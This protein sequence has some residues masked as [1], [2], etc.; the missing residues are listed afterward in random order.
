MVSLIFLMKPSKLSQGILLAARWLVEYDFPTIAADLIRSHGLAD[1]DLRS[2][3]EQDR[4][5]LGKLNDTERLNFRL[6]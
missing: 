1:C 2:M 5:V 4:L 6:G 3:E